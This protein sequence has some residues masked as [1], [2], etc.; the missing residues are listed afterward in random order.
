MQKVIRVKNVSVKSINKLIE[1][2]YLVI[3]CG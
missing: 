3:I 1:L 2:G